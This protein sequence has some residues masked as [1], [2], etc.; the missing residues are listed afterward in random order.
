MKVHRNGLAIL[1]VALLKSEQTFLDLEE[2]NEVVGSEDLTLNDR[3][4][5]FDLIEPARVDGGVHQYDGRRAVLD[6]PCRDQPGRVSWRRP[7]G[8][9]DR[10]W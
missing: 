8:S 5:D 4:V 2:R 6:G 10:A 3:E 7:R 9:N 1:V